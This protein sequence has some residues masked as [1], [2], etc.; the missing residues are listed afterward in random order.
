MN[1]LTSSFFLFRGF[2]P[3]QMKSAISAVTQACLLI[4]YDLFF[5]SEI[6]VR[7]GC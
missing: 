2:A 3:R 1:F 5:R 6:W 4:G 7:L